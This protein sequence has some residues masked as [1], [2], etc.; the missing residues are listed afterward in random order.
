MHIALSA[1][2][3]FDVDAEAADAAGHASFLY[4]EDEEGSTHI[5]RMKF[6]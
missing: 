1:R 6:I 5:T 4:W 2:H 3:A